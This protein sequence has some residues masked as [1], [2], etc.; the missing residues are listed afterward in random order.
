[1]SLLD[2]LKMENIDFAFRKGKALFEKN[3]APLLYMAGLDVTVIK[4]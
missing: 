1:M 4:V 2:L 3:A